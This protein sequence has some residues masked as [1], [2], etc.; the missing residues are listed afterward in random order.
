MSRSSPNEKE[1]ES[2]SSPETIE[3]VL[4]AEALLTLVG[5]I[6]CYFFL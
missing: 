4:E 1:T 3:T 5:F 6:S 2:R